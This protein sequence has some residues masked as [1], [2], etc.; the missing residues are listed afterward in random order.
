MARVR[1]QRHKKNIAL[2]NEYNECGE[3]KGDEFGMASGSSAGEGTG[4][5]CRNLSLQGYVGD[6]GVDKVSELE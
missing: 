1:P 5:G 4:F 6:I 2:L 3:V